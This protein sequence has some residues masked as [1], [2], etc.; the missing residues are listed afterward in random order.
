MVELNRAAAVGEANGSEASLEIVDRL[1]G[2]QEYPYLH[3]TRAELLRRAGKP[4]D[5]RE[6]YGR[7]I[8]LTY[9]E[10]ERRLFERRSAE[11]G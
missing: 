9:D 5:A 11:L 3:S 6:A 2:L 4:D 8:A 1:T 7:A 10:T